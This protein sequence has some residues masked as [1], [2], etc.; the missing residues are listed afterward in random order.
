MTL[1][2]QA[3]ALP[4]AAD[5]AQ[6]SVVDHELGHL[7][8]EAREHALQGARIHGQHRPRARAE[9]QF[10]GID[11]QPFAERADLVLRGNRQSSQPGPRRVRRDALSPITQV[12]FAGYH[13]RR[14]PHAG[15]LQRLLQPGGKGPC[16]LRVKSLCHGGNGRGL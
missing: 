1:G 10:V 4:K 8:A 12:E 15:S 2:L 13:R 6:H 7:A 16:L 5:Q 3:A 11:M 9:A 14:W